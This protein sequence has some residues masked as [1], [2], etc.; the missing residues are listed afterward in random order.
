MFVFTIDD[1]ITWGLFGIALLV[2]VVTLALEAIG[3]AIQRFSDKRNKRAEEALE[4][5][6]EKL[7]SCNGC[8]RFRECKSKMEIT[9]LWDNLRSFAPPFE[10][11]E[12]TEEQ[13]EQTTKEET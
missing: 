13:N 5:R 8:E 12:M 9:T 11:C 10:G 2:L 3:G 7:I 1:I 4:S 6:T